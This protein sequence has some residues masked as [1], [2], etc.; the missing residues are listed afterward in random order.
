MGLD[1]RLFQW[2]SNKVR[3]RRSSEQRVRDLRAAPAEPL[4]TRLRNVAAASADGPVNVAIVDGPGLIVGRLVLF[5]R[6]IDAAP[7]PEENIELLLVFATFA[8]ACIA[9]H[10]VVGGDDG[11][12]EGGDVAAF[13][14]LV[15]LGAID[16]RLVF[17]LAGYARARA[18]LAPSLIAQ[19][20]VPS[21]VAGRAAVLE[22][23][24][25]DRLGCAAEPEPR[26]AVAAVVSRAIAAAVVDDDL[27]AAFKAVG[28]KTTFVLPPCWGLMRRGTTGD[29]SA[30]K[31]GAASEPRGITT[32]LE[33]RKRPPARR[34]RT[35][36]EHKKAENPLTHSFEKVHTVEEHKGGQK[37]ADG[38]DE[39][40][41]HAAA[42]DE[43]ELEEVVLSS[44]TAASVY[45]AG[46]PSGDI[47]D[48]GARVIEGIRYDEWD[49]KRR[50][51][52][53]GYCHVS[54]IGG[55]VVKSTDLA[56]GAALLRR[57]KR[58]ERA[59]IEKARTAVLSIVSA[60][61]WQRRQLDGPEVDIDA[62]IDRIT[63]LRAGH[64][65]SR[66]VYQARRRSAREL[67]VLVLLDASFSTDAWV[68]NR[69]VLDVERDAATIIAAACDGLLDEVSIAAFFSD[70]HEDCRYIEL[71]GFDETVEVG[72]ARL[73]GL[74]PAGYTR[75]GPAIRHGVRQLAECRARRR[76][77]VILTD[78]KP[79][80][81][82]R[83]EGQHGEGD[84]RQAIREAAGDHVDVLALGADPRATATL[85]AM[86]GR[87]S[88]AG[89]SQASDVA[90]AVAEAIA[91]RLAR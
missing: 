69:R 41:D 31:S 15:K 1:E 45:N 12:D 32:E 58:D 73:S 21:S 54:A 8:G 87:R 29:G 5:P 75:L 86:C 60:R 6:T 50:R 17:D 88:A 34:R 9:H 66:N 62:A 11:D 76:L 56:R 61:R 72:A 3:G 39:L 25:R 16:Q 35:L 22:H 28:R 2:L 49:S 80:D 89:L 4:L 52:L 36:Q 68:D 59:A 19:R 43:V 46:A 51:Y 91:V 90:N 37:R 77:L 83:Y 65:G 71:R 82:D 30:A 64:E 42:L 44:E 67:A 79:G 40:A 85:W 47:D 18:S 38:S 13:R 70:T 48:V 55:G 26:A 27:V 81:R 24:V 57:V 23:L 84:V 20:A 53:P 33:G 74:E 63:T 78:G 10:A 7:S 14:A